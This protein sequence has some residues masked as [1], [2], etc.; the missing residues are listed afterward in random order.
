MYF[1]T[2]EWDDYDGKREVLHS[3]KSKREAFQPFYTTPDVS[4]VLQN[5][6]SIKDLEQTTKY[7]SSQFIPNYMDISQNISEYN[8]KVKF[9]HDNNDTYH[10]DDEENPN[11][12]IRHAEPKD[13]RDA[14]E[15]DINDINIY[16]NSIY[17][18]SAIACAT[19]LIAALM[20]SK[21]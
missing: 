12:L 11:V 15:H 6:K 13:I 4:S 17:I 8:K 19:F 10:Y 3:E 7:Q 1:S 16:Q 14:I 9:L 18:T 21:N 20:I 5:V 2:T